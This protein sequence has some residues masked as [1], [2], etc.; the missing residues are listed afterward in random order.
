MPF[1]GSRVK[2]QVAEASDE[3]MIWSFSG[4]TSDKR[5][6][7]RL[8]QGFEGAAGYVEHSIRD[9]RGRGVR[10]LRRA[11]AEDVPHLEALEGEHVGN[12]RAMTA[13]PDRLGAH[14]GGAEAAGQ[15]RQLHQ[16]AGKCLGCQVV[17]VAAKRGVR[18]PVL[19]E[20]GA[21]V[22]RPPSAG[23]QQ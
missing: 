23:N 13:P 20:S 22:R 9:A 1:T 4:R 8:G 14:D 11:G 10:I 2:V 18:Q 7:L 3:P 15:H 5:G 16:S 12:E 19:G 6:I 17:G 21:G